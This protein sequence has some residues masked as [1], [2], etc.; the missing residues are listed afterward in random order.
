MKLRLIATG[1]VIGLSSALVG[2]TVA[3]Q[4]EGAPPD[5]DAMMAMW[6]KVATP[7]EQHEMLQ[8]FVGEWDVT[9]R[10]MMDP[11]APP[12]ESKGTASF[13]P[14]LGGRF[15]Q[16]DY[17]CEFMGQPLEG[18]GLMG[19]DNYKKKFN[20]FWADNMGTAMY[21]AEGLLDQTGKVITCYGS[22]DEWMTGELD[23]AV[24]YVQRITGENSF[25]FEMHDLGIVP[26]E[27]KVMEIEYRRR[28]PAG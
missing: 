11:S 5:M 28:N 24:K 7:A 26:G 1:I 14:V 8:F 9:S 10:A 23:K 2:S 6:A 25:V 12:M 15:I 16:Q 4:D 13:V 27:T 22:M 21:N 19:F 18:I 17:K 3:S 20:M